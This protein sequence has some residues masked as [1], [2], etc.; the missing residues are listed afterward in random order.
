MCKLFKQYKIVFFTAILALLAWGRLLLLRGVWWDDWA[1]FWHYF[2]ASDLQG[3]IFPFQSLR[4]ELD[5][6]ILFFNFRLLGIFRENATNIWSIFK[7]AVFF[8]NSLALYL[9]SREISHKKSLLPQA[10]ALIYMV[11]PLVNNICLVEFSRRLYLFSFLFS[12]LFTL[13]SV[14]GP[15]FKMNYYLLSLLFSLVSILGLESFIIFDLSRLF[16]LVSIFVFKFKERLSKAVSRAILL[17]CPFILAAVFVLAYKMLFR[18]RFGVYAHTYDFNSLPF[19]KAAAFVVYK[20]VKS[21]FYIFGGNTLHSMRGVFSLRTCFLGVAA[22]LSLTGAIFAGFILFSNRPDI[23]SRSRIRY[24]YAEAGFGALFGLVL[25]LLGIFPYVMVKGISSSPGFGVNSRHALLASVGVAVFLAS[26]ILWLFYRGFIKKRACGF[27]FGLIIFAGIFQCNLVTEAYN[28]DWQQQ[29]AF[30]WQFIW[31]VPALK[32]KTYLLIDIPRENKDYFISAWMGHD[33]FSCPL[34]LIY[35]RSTAESDINTHFA[36]SFENAFDLT[37]KWS[38]I[39]NR[40][41]KESQF[42][43]HSGVQRFYPVNL[44]VAS[45]HNGCLFINEETSESN[46][47]GPVNTGPLVANAA[48]G[49]IIYDDPNADKV[50]HPL[51]WVI[52]SEPKA[53][54]KRS[55]WDR[56]N[57]EAFNRNIYKDWRYYLQRMRVSERL[58]DYGAVVSLYSEAESLGLEHRIPDALPLFV[59]KSFYLSG[60]LKKADFLLWNWALSSEGNL[61][62][63]EHLFREIKAIKDDPAIIG[64]IKAEIDRIW[65]PVGF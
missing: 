51:R 65:K 34:N 59:I 13:K 28:N 25:I 58:K 12:V 8:A 18:T 7:F 32:D 31:R 26:G 36:S 47:S 41:K 39:T 62:E 10:I 9:I 50:S 29:R 20:Y 27:L 2:K 49:Q 55:L 6:Y 40:D 45:Y 1:W 16:L 11:S 53:L 38:Y 61:R 5:G 15:K 3:F 21:L 33:E 24:F 63:A 4:H 30:W 23:N 35:A 64:E 19:F 46:S 14:C 48:P 42:D 44:M 17:Y 54:K 37:V 43:I 56:I 22:L 60:D 52:G 57:D